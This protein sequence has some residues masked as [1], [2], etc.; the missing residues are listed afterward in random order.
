MSS[1]RCVDPVLDSAEALGRVKGPLAALAAGVPLTRPARSRDLPS[2]R[3]MAE[4][5]K[6]ALQRDEHLLVFPRPTSSASRTPRDSGDLKENSTF[7]GTCSDRPSR[8]A[9]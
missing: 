7:A 5:G 1:R 2:Q 6:A 3:A 8:L 9:A 4:R